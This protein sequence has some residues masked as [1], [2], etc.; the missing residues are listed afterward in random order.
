MGVTPSTRP[1]HHGRVQ[2]LA[3]HALPGVLP[4]STLGKAFNYALARW[5]GFCACLDDGRIEIDNNLTEQQIKP[6]VI[7]RKNFM[8][9]HS[10]AGAQALC[11]HFSL[12]RTAK[13]HGLD[14]YR[15]YEAILKAVPHC[16]RVE[17]YEVLL[18]WNITLGAAH[19]PARAA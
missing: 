11:V 13:H 12:I 15:Y 9:S 18:P 4:K 10:V 19:V 7:A 17:D 8:F 2:G 5:D 1:T 3:R 16:H 6:F 14:P